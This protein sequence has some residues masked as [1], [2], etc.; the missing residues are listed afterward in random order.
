MSI[1]SLGLDDLGRQFQ[2]QITRHLSLDRTKPII[3][4]TEVWPQF[5]HST[6]FGWICRLLVDVCHWL[7]LCMTVF[8]KQDTS[9]GKLCYQN[10]EVFHP[11]WRRHTTGNMR[12]AEDNEGFQDQEKE[13]VHMICLFSSFQIFY[14]K[15]RPLRWMV[16]FM[17]LRHLAQI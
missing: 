10:M 8:C 4:K 11:T 1:C 17:A 3:V 14:F 2:T 7:S 13:M 5:F 12:E 15:T 6:S 16:A 9:Q